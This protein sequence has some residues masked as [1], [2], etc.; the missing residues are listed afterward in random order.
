MTYQVN[1]L[2]FYG[3]EQVVAD[4]PLGYIKYV[5]GKKLDSARLKLENQ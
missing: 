4:N 5:G 3:K 1:F 2:T